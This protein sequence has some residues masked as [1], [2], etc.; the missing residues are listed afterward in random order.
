MKPSVFYTFLALTALASAVEG[1]DRKNLL[2]RSV[3]LNSELQHRQQQRHRRQHQQ[4]Q[5]LLQS[6]DPTAQ[7][8]QG[9]EPFLGSIMVMDSCQY[10]M[11]GADYF[12]EFG[13]GKLPK[14]KVIL[15]FVKI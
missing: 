6:D 7:K 1:S 14:T 8:R 5:Q 11:C 15:K 13:Y 10:K 2:K 12:H 4:H 3:G 9:G